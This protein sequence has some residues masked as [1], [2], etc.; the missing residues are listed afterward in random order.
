MSSPP[1]RV[2]V[3]SDMQFS[4]AANTKGTDLQRA[5]EMY[6]QSG[7]LLPEVVFWNLAG[8]KGAPATAGEEG[9]ALVSGFSAG[10]MKVF[11]SQ[12]GPQTGL[13]GLRVLA[14]ALDRP[15][16]RRPRVVFSE[17]EALDLF[18]CPQQAVP[19]RG[20]AARAPA[21]SGLMGAP[22]AQG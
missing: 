14:K 18:R 9:V 1:K 20:A 21:A 10:M 12:G 5:K 11:L 4:C 8:H 22:T 6:R 15:L 17:A 7:K 13:E 2:F 19:G 16:L 3:F